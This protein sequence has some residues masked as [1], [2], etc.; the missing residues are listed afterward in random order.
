MEKV[1]VLLRRNATGTYEEVGEVITQD[2][3]R[4]TVLLP[5]GTKIQHQRS[6]GELVPDRGS[7]FHILRLDPSAVEQTLQAQPERI[8]KQLMHDAN[9]P[10]VAKDLKDKMA[11][12]FKIDLIDQSWQRARTALASDQDVLRHGK[13]GAKYALR[14]G[15]TMDLL[16]LLPE[17]RS[18]SM[19]T[20][21]PPELVVGAAD[22]T[23]PDAANQT[24][25][26]DGSSSDSGVPL[27]PGGDLL[28]VRLGPIADELRLLTLGDV[29]RRPLA[30]SQRVNRMSAVAQQDLVTG[31][32][33]EQSRLLALVAGEAQGRAAGY[34]GGRSDGV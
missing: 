29:Y 11:Q 18:R 21:E 20:D 4:L 10:L 6:P 28:V 9:K 32:P 2:K 27:P 16:D 33:P 30:V 7:F 24:D 23:P 17:R 25:S 31:L 5:D 22:Q 13:D 26:D 14:A 1:K 3:K 19:T 12:D 8:Y 34:P 15:V